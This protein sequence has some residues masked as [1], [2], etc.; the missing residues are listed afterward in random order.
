MAKRNTRAAP[1]KRTALKKKKAPKGPAKKIG[2]KSGKGRTS[3]G[4]SHASKPSRKRMSADLL[5]RAGGSATTAGVS[6]QASVGAVFA[7]QMLAEAVMD[8]RLGLGGAKP[9]GIRF[10]SEAAVDDCGVE[11]D[12]GGWIFIQAKTGVTLSNTADS[13]LRKTA[14][15]MVRLWHSAKKGRGKK[16]WDR[17]LDLAKDRCLLAAGPNSSG[18]A[19]RDLARALNARRAKYTAPLPNAQKDALNTFVKALK[20]EWKA[21]TKETA[22]ESDIRA[23]LPFIVVIPF[24]MAGADRVAAIAGTVHLLTRASAAANAFVAIEKHCQH[25]MEGR[26]GDAAEQFRT[27][28]SALGVSLKAP[29]RYEA[30]VA[31]L[32]RYSEETGRRLAEFEKTTVSGVDI[33]I[34]RDVT[35]SVVDAAKN[36]SFLVIGEPG[37]GKSAVISAAAAALR[38]QKYGVIELA[39]DQ[40]PVVSAEG[41]RLELGLEH[42]VIDVLDNWP[43][44]KPAFLFIDALDATRGGAGEHVFRGLIDAVVKRPA[45]RWKVIASIRSFDLRMG[46]Q[47]RLL[48][49]GAPPAAAYASKDFADIRH[50]TVPPWNDAEFAALHANAPPLDQAI[51]RG[52]EKLRDLA[53]VPFNTRLLAELITNGATPET[54]NSVASQVELLALYWRKRVEQHGSGAELCLGAAVAEMVADRSLRARRTTAAAPDPDAFDAVLKDG[55]VMLLSDIRLIGFRHHILFD[56]AASRLFIDPLNI[57]ATV[58]RLRNDRGLSLMLAPAIVGN[59]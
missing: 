11:T 40:L 39:V 45:S 51:T 48:F 59:R 15:Q 44:V 17:P 43:G 21:L 49:K 5:A 58:E 38:E 42:R 47:F 26:L 36:G 18:S 53:R 56:Y 23:I 2:K 8:S 16:G 35:Q 6:F 1:R 32:A 9:C 10:E 20:A 30:D 52:G 27:A 14:G 7:V 54:F 12:A 24:D 13:D 34:P 28:L 33:T 41:M 19:T 46:E 57:A 50:I 4:R 37:A 3:P 55:V 31:Q 22:R 29:P 25:L